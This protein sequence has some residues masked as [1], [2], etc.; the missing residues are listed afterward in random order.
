MIPVEASMLFLSFLLSAF[1]QSSQE[2]L[3]QKCDSEIPWI[4]DGAI[5]PGNEWKRRILRYEHDRDPLLEEAREQARRRRR[6]ILWFCPRVPGAHMYRARSLEDYA[7]SVLFTDSGVV[8]LVRTKFVPLRMCCDENLSALTGVRRFDFVEPGILILSPDGKI[9][10]VLDR[11]RTFNATWLRS[12]LVAI[13]RKHPEFNE[14]AG[15]SADDLLR[16]GDDD[17]A[18]PKA[19]PEQKAVILRRAGRTGEVH[20]MEGAAL[21]KGLASLQDGR[22]EEARRLLEKEGSPEALYHLASVD[23][24]TGRNPEPRLREV[25]ERY[26]DTRWGWRAAANLRRGDDGFLSG[27]LPR[28]YEDVFAAPDPGAA[29]ATRTPNPD[30]DAVARRALAFLLRAQREDGSWKDARFPFS[31]NAAVLANYWVSV[32]ALA[33]LALAEWRDLDPA[34]VD[35]A[36]RRAEAWLADER[37]V[38]RGIAPESYADAYRLLAFA[39]SKDAARLDALVAHLAREQDGAG[40]WT[41]GYA[42]PFTTGAVVHCL[43]AARR[44]GAEVPEAVLRRAADA[45]EGK[46]GPGTRFCYNADRT[47]PST[48]KESMTRKALCEMALV[49]CGRSSIREVAAGVESYWN[50]LKRLEAVRVCDFHADGELAGFSFFHAAFFTCEAATMLPEPERRANLDRFRAQMLSIPELDGSFID[51]HDLGKSYG[52]ANA[53]LILK[54]AR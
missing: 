48:E 50:H 9:L 6:L 18:L 14:P 36:L 17:L 49:Q 31:A 51:S 43:A 28:G 5:L 37:N 8:D 3:A 11:I 16:G 52:T 4:S 2:A 33:T 23:Y 38:S 35:P 21:Q 53:L 13:L 44:A 29:T 41:H 25:V 42:N 24:W 26:P 27:P 32:S 10:H 7:K 15:E 54:R 47:T 30:A 45:I 39:R 20:A 19:S 22:L 1:A 40:F 46:R 34:R 12:A